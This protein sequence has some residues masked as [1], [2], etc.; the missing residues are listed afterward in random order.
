MKFKLKITCKKVRVLINDFEK[1]TK[2]KRGE[3]HVPGNT[4]A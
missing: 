4:R 2:R 3:A 1:K